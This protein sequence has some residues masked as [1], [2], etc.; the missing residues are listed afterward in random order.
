MCTA[1][2]YNPSSEV[3]VQTSP[4]ATFDRKLWASQYE[5]E[6]FHKT[7]HLT[8]IP[9][10]Q[11][12]LQSRKRFTVAKWSSA[13][14]KVQPLTF[15]VQTWMF[16]MDILSYYNTYVYQVSLQSLKRMRSDCLDKRK[17]NLW[18]WHSQSLYEHQCLAWHFVSSP[19]ICVPSFTTNPQ[20]VAKWSSAQTL[21]DGWTG[22]NQYTPPKS[23]LQGA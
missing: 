14:D 5:R 13:Q 19:Y 10:Y 21:P 6:C 16:R 15:T 23:R 22:W 1:F 2:H 9:I 17:C 18:L 3:I 4:N 20:A 12:S 11:V 8:T 7:V